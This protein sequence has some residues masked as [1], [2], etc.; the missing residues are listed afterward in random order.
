MPP[1]VFYGSATSWHIWA[2]NTDTF[3]P[4]A[5]AFYAPLPN[6]GSHGGICWGTNRAPVVDP[7]SIDGALELFWSSPFSSHDAAGRSV[8]HKGDVRRLL[9]KLNGKSTFPT[10][11]LLS[12][13]ASI[14]TVIDSLVGRFH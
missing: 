13:G 8:T 10:K 7:R 3:S 12:C 5:E 11:Q 4:D 9:V 14:G 6:I 2:L 1:L